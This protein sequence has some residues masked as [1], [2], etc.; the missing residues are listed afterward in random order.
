L[1]LLLLIGVY[2]YSWFKARRW[3]LILS[4][5]LIGLTAL[6]DLAGVDVFRRQYLSLAWPPH[7]FYL[8][9]PVW[10]GL[11][12][13]AL[14]RQAYLL[15]I[16]GAYLVILVF[17]TDRAPAAAYVLALW[18]IMLWALLSW[19]RWLM[20]VTTTLI[21]V[22]FIVGF[23][24]LYRGRDGRAEITRAYAAIKDNF[25]S[26]DKIYAFQL[27]DYYLG[28][29]PPETEIIDL[30]VSSDPEFS[31]SGFVVWEEEK[32][33]HLKPETLEYI[34]TN[35]DYLGSG[36]VEIYRYNTVDGQN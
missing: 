9:F 1:T 10:L 33:T 5:G 26:G 20:V 17:F 15:T 12:T 23:N 19:K 22:Q 2:V 4:T 32:T 31:G 29:L 14:K 28:D 3:F 11:V 24:Y 34:K 21:L 13:L 18:P 16:T 8:T 7:W 6:G 30:Q 25:E 36:G 27:R 35:F